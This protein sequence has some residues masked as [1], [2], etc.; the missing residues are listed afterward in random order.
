MPNDPPPTGL[1]AA[2]QDRLRDALAQRPC[3]LFS[4]VDGTLSAIAPTPAAAVLLPGVRELLERAL[5][6]FEVVAAVSGRAAEDTRRLVGIAG[7]TYLGNHGLERLDPDGVKLHILP[8]AEPYIRAINLV[9]AEVE[10]PLAAA[11]PGLL[12]ERKGVTASIHVRNTAH[13]D[14]AERE[15]YRRAVAAAQKHGL[16]V[17]QGK[18]IVELRPPL[19]ASKGTAVA[20]LVREAGLRGAL[21]LGDDRTDIDAFRALR[22]LTDEGVCRGVAVAVLHPEALPG[23]AAEADVTLPS[24]ER[25]PGLLRWL[26]E[27]A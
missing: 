20:A 27:Q 17:T 18:M 6:R 4:D 5:A 7:I 2:A 16:R 8:E 15:V 10:L 13:P 1:D 21:Y 12:F 26:L 24:V 11:Y 3:G 22:R 23:L 9:M 14:A 19:Q 25:V